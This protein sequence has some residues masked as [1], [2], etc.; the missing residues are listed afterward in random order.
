[1]QNQCP[2][3]SW[4]CCRAAALA[5]TPTSSGSG[6]HGVLTNSE[7][8]KEPISPTV[9]TPGHHNLQPSQ[10]HRSEQSMRRFSEA[11]SITDSQQYKLQVF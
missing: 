10:D 6:V 8:K 4:E 5:A 2:R 11:F 7:R 3:K 1:M 9:T